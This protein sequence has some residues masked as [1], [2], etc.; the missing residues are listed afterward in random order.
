MNVIDRARWALILMLAA[1]GGSGGGVTDVTGALIGE[2]DDDTPAGLLLTG[3]TFAART[4]AP[5][6]DG[7][8]GAAPSVSMVEAEL[9]FLRSDTVNVRLDGEDNFLVADSSGLFTEPNGGGS[10]FFSRGPVDGLI[11]DEHVVGVIFQ[12]SPVSS[13]SQ[14]VAMVIGDETDP[15]ALPVDAR[16]RYSGYGTVIALDT[17]ATGIRVDL[18]ADF[19]FDTVHGTV[20]EMVRSSP[21]IVLNLE[22]ATLS[23]DGF[24]GTLSSDQIDIDASEMTGSFFGTNGQSL[25]GTVLVSSDVVTANGYYIAE[26]QKEGLAQ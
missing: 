6:P 24:T 8:S 1:C 3:Q 2:P 13:T 17:G 7:V 22:G 18:T 15:S 14:I 11:A 25:A 10:L 16:A 21:G 19:A 4:A 12:E 9:E 20:H 5:S 23:D 26:E